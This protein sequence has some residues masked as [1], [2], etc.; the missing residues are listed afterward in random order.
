MHEALDLIASAAKN[1]KS[2]IRDNNELRNYPRW[3]KT[4]ET[5]TKYNMK[6]WLEAKEW[7]KKKKV[8]KT[9]DSK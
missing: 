7:I 5:Q 6:N 4:K 9:G 3:E 8:V 2:V 1:T